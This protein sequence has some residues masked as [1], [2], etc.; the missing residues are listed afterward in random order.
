MDTSTGTIKLK[1]TFPNADDKLWPG[2]FVNARLQLRI[3]HDAVVVPSAAV[4][5]GV[6]GLYT[7][8]VQPDD[9]AKVVQIQIGQDDGQWTI[10]TAG[11]KGGETVVTGGQSRL[12]DGL[13][14]ASNAAKPGAGAPAKVG[15]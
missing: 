5:R 3:Q 1:A 11:L 10:V 13:R 9:V 8:V 2:Q 4:L 15:G 7:Y 12:A 6:N 14:V